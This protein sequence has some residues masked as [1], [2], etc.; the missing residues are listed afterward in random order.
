[1]T[2][3][4]LPSTSTSADEQNIK[5]NTMEVPIY[6]TYPQNAY[7]IGSWDGAINRNSLGGH[8]PDAT[9]GYDSSAWMEPA[10]MT[11]YD[12]ATA[13]Y[14]P[15]LDDAA[16]STYGSLPTTN[17]Y[18]GP[19]PST[20]ASSPSLGVQ[21]QGWSHAANDTAGW[22]QTHP[23][24]TCEVPFYANHPFHHTAP[25]EGGFSSGTLHPTVEFGAE[26]SPPPAPSSTKPASKPKNKGKGKAPVI[27]PAKK[28]EAT[29]KARGTKRKSPTPPRGSLKAKATP[30]IG[31]FP[32]NV[33]PKKASEKMQ[34][35]AWEKAKTEALAMSQRRLMLLDHERGALDRETQK[36]QVNIGLMREQVAKQHSELQEAISKAEKLKHQY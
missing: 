25:S 30:H 28:S 10:P 24:P 2:F 36:L 3:G 22:D 19:S 34:R 35:E 8:V 23:S 16:W 21:G 17:G 15:A 5:H 6:Q 12:A 26:Q 7:P 33:D 1:M 27:K 18:D 4:N 9:G 31:I 29:L 11:G 20:V 13:L 32:P 14:A